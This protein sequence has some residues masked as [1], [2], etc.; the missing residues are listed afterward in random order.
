[1]TTAGT[2]KNVLNI[3]ICT[4]NENWFGKCFKS[5]PNWQELKQHYLE[6]N[7]LSGIN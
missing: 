3:Y 4:K 2:E 6:V 1:M 5:M 7:S